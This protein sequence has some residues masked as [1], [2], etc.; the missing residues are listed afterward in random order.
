M[1]SER[2]AVV[3]SA[4][5]PEASLKTAL[6][7]GWVMNTFFVPVEKLTALL[8][9]ELDNTVVLANVLLEYVPRPTSNWVSPTIA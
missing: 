8:E 5:L 1:F 2:L 9:L 6:P 7:D 3:S 4:I